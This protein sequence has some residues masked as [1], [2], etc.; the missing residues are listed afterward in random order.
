MVETPEGDKVAAVGI[1]SLK[2]SYTLHCQVLH[3]HNACIAVHGA[4]LV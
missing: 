4:V 3:R 2:H 1:S